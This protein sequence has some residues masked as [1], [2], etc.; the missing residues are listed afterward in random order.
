MKSFKVSLT[1]ERVESLIKQIVQGTVK[2]VTP[3]E[4]GELSRVFSFQSD[5]QPLIVHFKDDGKS[6]EKAQYMYMNFGERLP[7][8]KVISR[9]VI[10]NVHYA[11]SEKAAGTAMDELSIEAVQ[12]PLKD[13]AEQVT[14]MG[15]IDVPSTAGFQFIDPQEN[16]ASYETMTELIASHFH[17]EP[18][19]FY[20]NWTHLYHDSFLEKD[21]F[22]AGYQ[23]LIE[24]TAFAPKTPTLVHGDFHLGNMLANDTKVTGIVDWEM[25]SFSDFMMDVANVHL[26]APQLH[27]PTLLFQANNTIPHFSERLQCYMLFR[28]V[29]GLRFYAKQ[30]AKE[31]YNFIKGK[32]LE[33]L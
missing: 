9:G 32:L 20:E 4:K 21:V 1:M 6:F 13:L 19:G 10:E 12:W 26:W 11:I 30:D 15:E 33:L 2:N 14:R 31:S 25:A 29:D 23:R 27:F 17:E 16:E 18:S 8:P 22:Q 3:I 5:E 24:L 7:I 28:T